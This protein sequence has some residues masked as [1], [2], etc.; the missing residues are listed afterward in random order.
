M[1][2]S[3][4]VI[5]GIAYVVLEARTKVTRSLAGKPDQARRVNES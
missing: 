3:V 1:V 5:A 2:L 4:S